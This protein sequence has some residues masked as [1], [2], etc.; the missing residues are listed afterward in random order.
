MIRI[1]PSFSFLITRYRMF[2]PTTRSYVRSDFELNDD[3]NTLYFFGCTKEGIDRTFEIYDRESFCPRN[4]LLQ[5]IDFAEKD[6]RVCW[7]K[8]GDYD[9]I[10]DRKWLEAKLGFPIPKNEVTD[11]RNLPGMRDFFTN[12]PNIQYMF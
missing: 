6:E 1:F 3:S 7:R 9:Y 8:V 11:V 5:T 2:D 10:E 4:D 12:Y